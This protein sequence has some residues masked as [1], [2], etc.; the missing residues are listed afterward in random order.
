MLKYLKCQTAIYKA[1]DLRTT[2]M[3][4]G[5]TIGRPKGTITAK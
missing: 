1:G 5:A 4:V 3:T 2:D